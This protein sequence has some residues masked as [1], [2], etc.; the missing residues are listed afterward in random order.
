MDKKQIYV[1]V[2][3]P[4]RAVHTK[5]HPTAC[6]RGQAQQIRLLCPLLC[7]RCPLRLL[8]P[9]RQLTRRPWLMQPVE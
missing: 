7:P 3:N 5:W 6:S 2:G 4:R 8:C 9:L 1:G